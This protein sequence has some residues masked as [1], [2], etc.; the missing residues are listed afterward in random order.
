MKTYLEEQKVDTLEE[1][2]KLSDEF[3][4]THKSFNKDHQWR[5][6]VNNNYRGGHNN[7]GSV[8]NNYNRMPNK[9]NG[10]N[11]GSNGNS[12]RSRKEIKCFGCGELGHIKPRCPKL[13][14]GRGKPVLLLD[15][16]QVID[17]RKGLEVI[18]RPEVGDNFECFMSEAVISAVSSPESVRKVTVL[19]DTAATQ[20][21]VVESVL[22]TGC[23]YIEGEVV[24]LRGFPDSWTTCPLVMINLDSPLV[25]GQVRV[26]VVKQLPV[27]G[28]DFLLANDYAGGKVGTDPRLV[29]RPGERQVLG[30]NVGDLNIV[31]PI[32]VLT[33]SQRKSQLS[34]GS[35]FDLSPLFSDSSA[36]TMIK[37]S[38]GDVVSDV[39]KGNLPKL[40][41]DE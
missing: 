15:T 18:N 2:A 10:N 14:G 28:V 33:R 11:Y 35:E 29:C 36:E 5:N 26:A 24:V 39:A 30:D 4:L 38:S 1:A 32:S 3:V 13:G 8:N 31:Q 22:P 21:V 17:G 27:K 20:S 12:N 23:Q 16:R 9:G 19:R 7:S 34:S 6:K 40:K 25:K 41:T 37:G